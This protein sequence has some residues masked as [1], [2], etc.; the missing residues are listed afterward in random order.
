MTERPLIKPPVPRLLLRASDVARML[1]VSPG[2]VADHV[3]PH[4]PYVLAGTNMKLY[5][6]TA[7]EAW[8]AANT[9]QPEDT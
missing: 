1:G 7:V 6:V 8:I 4:L 2:F 9:R 5:P 3:L